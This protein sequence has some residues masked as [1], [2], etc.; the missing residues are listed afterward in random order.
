MCKCTPASKPDKWQE[1]I[2][3]GNT[4]FSLNY[5]GNAILMYNKALE[6]ARF[7]FEATARHSHERA[8]SKVVICYFSLADCYIKLNQIV[9][10]SDFY[11]QA[12]SFLLSV[13]ASK[14][15]KPDNLQ[16]A[17]DHAGSHINTLWSD[18]LKKYRDQVSYKRILRH[19]QASLSLKN[20]PLNA[21]YH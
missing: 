12:Q 18:F 10:A 16:N 20:E 17:I 8:I 4:E 3:R 13:N 14:E 15:Q 9:R 11:A 5:F 6:D 1:C 19:H 2:S 7:Q 21:I